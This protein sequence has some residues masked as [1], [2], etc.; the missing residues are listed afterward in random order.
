MSNFDLDWNVNFTSCP[1]WNCVD[2][3]IIPIPIYHLLYIQVP[4]Y[5]W[6]LIR[7]LVV[8]LHLFKRLLQTHLIILTNQRPVLRSR[9]KSGPIRG[10][11]PVT[12]PSRCRHKLRSPVSWGETSQNMLWAA[13]S[14]VRREG[15]NI[16]LAITDRRVFRSVWTMSIIQT[17]YQG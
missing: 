3:F 14:W 10:Q 2:T 13:Q 6:S 16:Y 12:W 8:C 17:C 7:Q 5:T 15:S 9:D 1:L 11:F 4:M